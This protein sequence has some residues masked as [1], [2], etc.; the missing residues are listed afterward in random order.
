MM[1]TIDRARRYVAK[2]DG[3]VSHQG[4]H[5]ATFRVAAAL[6]HGFALDD[7]QAL[8]LL[9]EWNP[10]CQPPWSE[11][12]LQPRFSRRRQRRIQNRVGICWEMAAGMGGMGRRGRRWGRAF[13]PDR[14]SRCSA[15]WC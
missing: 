3:A 8:A 1:T 4:G 5:G 9:R 11:A 6:V 12:E 15:R 10:S 13:R 2:I 7:S 14:Q